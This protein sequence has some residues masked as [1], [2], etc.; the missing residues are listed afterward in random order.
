MRPDYHQIGT[1]EEHKPK[2]ASRTRSRLSVQNVMPGMPFGLANAPNTSLPV[3]RE[4]LGELLDKT[5]LVHLGDVPVLSKA[6]E[7]HKRDMR[8]GAR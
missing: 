8:D 4:V 5:V 3:M 6:A 2:T 7:E 1:N